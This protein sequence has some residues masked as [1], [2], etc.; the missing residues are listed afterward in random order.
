VPSLV[1]IVA[2]DPLCS[3]WARVGAIRWNA[4]KPIYAV[5]C[6]AQPGWLQPQPITVMSM[7]FALSQGAL[8]Y[9][10]SAVAIHLQIGFAHFP[11]FSSAMCLASLPQHHSAVSADTLGEKEI[12]HS[13]SPNTPDRDERQ[14]RRAIR[15]R[16][17][18][19]VPESACDSPGSAPRSRGVSVMLPVRTQPAEHVHDQCH[20]QHRPEDPQ[21]TAGPPLGITVVAA[22]SAEQQH[23][24][25][26]EQ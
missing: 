24:H 3:V 15:P 8:Q 2:M 25:N 22:A 4:K 10:L 5:T 17:R 1:L 13:D 18:G 19:I 11:C 6:P 23:Q 26:N 14:G 20:E 16:G 9:R 7:P 21:A 12:R